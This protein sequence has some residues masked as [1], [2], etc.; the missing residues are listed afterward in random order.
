MLGGTDEVEILTLNLVHHGIHI[1]LAHNALDNV[2]VDHER[3]D[4]VDKAFIYHKVA[5]VG[6]DC[7]VQA[8]NVTHEVVE[9]VAG[10]A[11]CGI[12]IYAVELFHDL[13]VIRNLIIGSYG[14]AEALDL[15]ICAVIGA[16]GNGGVNDVGD[17]HHEDADALRVLLL[18]LLKL[19]ET[20]CI[21]LD[22]SLDLLCL[23]KLGRVLFCLTHQHTDL[24]GKSVAAGAEL[25][26]FGYGCSVLGIELKNLI[27][28]RELCILKLLLD[29]FLDYIGIFSDKLD[30]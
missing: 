1:G 5:C 19:C 11:A 18:K 7:T 24:L 26:C 29:I 12:H 27:N 6:E 2:A 13:S 16:D 28:H 15:N 9:A 20:V 23:F 10:N 30:I 21:C 4:A 17:V 3:G 8:G 22:L 25:A 14:L